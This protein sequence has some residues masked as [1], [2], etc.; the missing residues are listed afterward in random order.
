[1][2]KKIE[3]L[4]TKPKEVRNRY[5]FWCAFGFTAVVA[6][7]WLVSVPSQLLVFSNVEEVPSPEV[8][9]GISRSMSDL[10]ASVANGVALFNKIKEGPAAEDEELGTDKVEEIDFATFFSTSSKPTAEGKVPVQRGR[11]VLIGTTS[12]ARSSSTED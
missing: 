12:Q 3:S 1:M 8:E 6:V 5:A 9:G 10:R 11:S 2:L 7:F 4:R